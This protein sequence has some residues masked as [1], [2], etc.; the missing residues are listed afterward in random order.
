MPDR[1]N[2]SNFFL[3]PQTLD[4][5]LLDQFLQ[6]VIMVFIDAFKITLSWLVRGCEVQISAS[7]ALCKLRPQDSFGLR[8]RRCCD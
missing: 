3:R 1:A 4:T 7:P 2:F 8:S 5:I 6:A